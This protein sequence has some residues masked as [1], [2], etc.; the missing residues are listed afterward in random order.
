[1]VFVLNTHTV[2]SYASKQTS[3][4][5]FGCASKSIILLVDPS[6]IKICNVTKQEVLLP[7]TS[8]KGMWRGAG[9]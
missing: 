7:K 2:K 9:G 3:S 5:T 8:T 1:M 4:G 6:K